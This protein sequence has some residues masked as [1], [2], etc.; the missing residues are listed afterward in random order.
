MSCKLI[1][2]IIRKKAKLSGEQELEPGLARA[3]A[4]IRR[5]TAAS[6]RNRSA[7]SLNATDFVP[8]DRVYRNP[9]AF[10]Q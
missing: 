7:M 4:S 9:T 10:Y 1:Q 6:K 5:A 8:S 2:R 3:R